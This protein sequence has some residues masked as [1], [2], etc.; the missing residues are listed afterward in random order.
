MNK[1]EEY[2]PLEKLWEKHKKTEEYSQSPVGDPQPREGYKKLRAPSTTLLQTVG[3]HRTLPPHHPAL[4]IPEL[5]QVFGPL[6]FPLIRAAL[7]RKRILILGEAPVEITCNYVYGL[8]ILSS[9]S[10][11]VAAHIP[12][13]D[14]SKA[15]PRSLFNVGISDI[16]KLENL[17]GPWI[18]CTTDD[19][20]TSKPHLFDMLVILPTASILQKQSNKSYPK[21]IN[22]TPELSK[23]FPKQIIR[24]TQR[25]AR[26]ATAL[27]NSVQ[28]L[29]SGAT[30]AYNADSTPRHHDPDDNASTTTASSA[31]TL[32]D[33]KE[34]VEPMPWSV[35]AYTSLVWWASAGDRRSG[36]ME[37]EE[38]ANEQDEALL[39]DTLAGEGTT[40]EVAVV[41]YFHKLSSLAFEVLGGAVRR[42]ENRYRDEQDGEENGVD[43]TGS[44]SQVLLPS[45]DDEAV[46][47]TEEDV[48]AMGLDIWSEMNRRFV[49]E[50]VQLWW[51]GKAVVRGGS[52]E[53]CGIRLM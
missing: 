44:D 18:A 39:R 25:D 7:L 34:A 6:L 50:M 35:I 42:N 21:L 53:C 2:A 10:R 48:R 15:S 40:K 27:K 52:I 28:T 36:L 43:G 51:G 23:Q 38:L 16:P 8:S 13:F 3:I 33:H 5:L 26:R 31:D 22:S 32:I 4:A 11:T 49:E 20:L 14:H 47:I 45:K 29:A 17:R 46:E 37:A 41:A 9:I 12:D 24:A 30:Y 1:P 19:V